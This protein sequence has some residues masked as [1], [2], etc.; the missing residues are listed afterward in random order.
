MKTMIENLKAL[1]VEAES[2]DIH[3][4]MGIDYN[5]GWQDCLEYLITNLETMTLE[6]KLPVEN[7]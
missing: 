6:K 2:E 5:L 7:T 3:D 1:L 4:G